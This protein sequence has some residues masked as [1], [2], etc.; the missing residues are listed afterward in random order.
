MRSGWPSWLWRLHGDPAPIEPRF[1][2]SALLCILVPSLPDHPASP[3]IWPWTATRFE[4]ALAII[5]T[6][7]IIVAGI[8]ALA[9]VGT[10][11]AARPLI[12]VTIPPDPR[13]H[14]PPLAPAGYASRDL[15]RSRISLF[16]STLR[17]P[18]VKGQHP[19]RAGSPLWRLLPELRDVASFGGRY[20][21]QREYSRASAPLARLRIRSAAV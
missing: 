16:P 12:L 19:P 6:S 9:R 15:S 2:A 4:E 17:I 10:T 14:S 8:V 18:T 21:Q 1:F 11:D 5:V 7:T 20:L 3:T 13:S